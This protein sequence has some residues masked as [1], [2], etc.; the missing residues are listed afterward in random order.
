MIDDPC[1]VLGVIPVRIDQEPLEHK[2][3]HRH[4]PAHEIRPLLWVGRDQVVGV[5]PGRQAQD[6]DLGPQPPFEPHQPAR[7]EDRLLLPLQRL[8]GHLQAAQRGLHAGSIRIQGQHQV[9]GR[10]LQPPYLR[11]G[12]SGAHL[13][14]HVGEPVLV[15]PQHPHVSLDHHRL[16]LLPDRPPGHI[17]PEQGR[18]L[19]KDHGLGRVDV[20]GRPLGIERAGPKTNCVAPPIPDGDHQPAPEAVVGGPILPLDQQPGPLHLLNRKPLLEQVISQPVPL[21]QAV[22]QLK[23]LYRLLGQP[24][25]LYVLAGLLRLGCVQQQVVVVRARCRQCVP[26]PVALFLTLHLGW[27]PWL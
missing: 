17:Q 7:V 26:E 24:A 8:P 9:A 6:P 18:A 19:V 16:V 25:L 15:R 5:V 23:A 2:L 12:Q 4:C 27:G 13:G 11:L 10:A 14:H 22:S 1:S 3:D 20:L 21:V